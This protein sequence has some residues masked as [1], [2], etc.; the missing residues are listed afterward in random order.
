VELLEQAECYVRLPIL[1]FV[2]DGLELVVHAE[3]TNLVPSRTQRTYDVILG[4]PDINFL[5]GVTLA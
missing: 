3:R 5:F 4:F 1:D 2:A